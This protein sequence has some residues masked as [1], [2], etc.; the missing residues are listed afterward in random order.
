ME[1]NAPFPGGWDAG[2]TK[3]VGA[4]DVADDCLSVG[5]GDDVPGRDDVVHTHEGCV[6]AVGDDGEWVGANGRY[7][8]DRFRFHITVTYCC[9]GWGGSNTVL[10]FWVRQE[11][12]A[13]CGGHHGSAV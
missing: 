11:E 6:V 7:L 9:A 2:Y 5:K 10:P 4:A 3:C 8:F 13:G 1:W 12:T